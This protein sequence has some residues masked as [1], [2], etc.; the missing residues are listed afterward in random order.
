MLLL[1][2]EESLNIEVLENKYEELYLLILMV[3]VKEHTMRIRGI[4]I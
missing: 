1:R 2:N 3:F 4:K